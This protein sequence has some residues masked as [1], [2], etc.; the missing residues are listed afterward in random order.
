MEVE[1]AHAESELNIDTEDDPV[2]WVM[3]PEKSTMNIDEPLDNFICW[4]P[5]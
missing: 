3:E 2:N 5:K 4:L 1:E